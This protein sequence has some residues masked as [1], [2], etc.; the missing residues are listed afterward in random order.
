MSFGM[1]VTSVPELRS[2]AMPIGDAEEVL[3]VQEAGS[4]HTSDPIRRNSIRFGV[5]RA[6]RTH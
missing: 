2:S 3:W 5:D 1:G 4:V 6:I